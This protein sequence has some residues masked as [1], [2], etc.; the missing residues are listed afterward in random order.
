[1]ARRSPSIERRPAFTLTLSGRGL[2][3]EQIVSRHPAPPCSSRSPSMSSDDSNAGINDASK[4]E[5]FGPSPVKPHF[6]LLFPRAMLPVALPGAHST[7]QN[8]LDWVCDLQ[9]ELKPRDVPP[10]NLQTR[11]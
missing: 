1:M 3:W 6:F 9:V 10:S 11:H 8:E 2:N 4:V 7:I 5:R